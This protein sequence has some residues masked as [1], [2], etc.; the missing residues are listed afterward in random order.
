MSKQIQR[1]V[2]VG[3][4]R[5][6]TR[7]T[8]EADADFWVP[9]IDFDFTP[10]VDVAVDSSGLGVID[11][12]Q[13]SEVT[14]KYGE[15]SI[16]GIVY[17]ESFGLL[18]GLALGTWSTSTDDPEVDVNTHSFTRLNT[19][20]HPAATIFVKDENLD[21]KY[22]LG[23]LNQLS[24]NAVV[25]DYVKFTAG[26]MSKD[27]TTTSTTPSYATDESAFVPS[28]MAFKMATTT[29]GLGAASETNLR[30]FSITINKNVEAWNELGS[31]EPNDIVNKQFS[32]E[33]EIE[34][35][36]DNATE[37]DYVQDGTKM[38][39]SVELTNTDVT[40]GTA[41]NPKL[42]FELAP[43]S[44]EEFG[45]SG[46]ADDVEVQTLGF[47]GNFSVSDSKTIS[48]ELINSQTSY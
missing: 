16:G 3:L 2:D 12:R 10:T 47:S 11:A 40:I 46:G 29:G 28:N 48:A 14:L 5:E 4:G 31:R 36:F 20:S 27:G 24:V 32:V 13:D 41:S 45:R 17:S 44:F 18:L 38:A 35:V 30:S 25:D 37:R 22:A 43:V 19:N 1:L 34:L 33:G 9:K 7:G 23:M 42:S 26:F 8:A 6:T 15:G 21:E 39:M